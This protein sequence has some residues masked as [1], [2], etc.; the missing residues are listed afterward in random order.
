MGGG[1]SGTST[2]V[3]NSQ[4]WSG[5]EPY[6]KYGFN[7]AKDIY[8]SGLPQYYPGS[9]VVPFSPQTEAALQ[10]TEN[11]ALMGNPLN[12][13]AQNYANSVLQ[14]DYLNQGNPYIGQLTQ[15]ISD[16]ITPQVQSA[17]AGAN[18]SG[19]A[20]QTE[21]L[22]RGMTNALAP[23][24]FGNY[25]QE[26]G[27]QQQAM[28]AAPGLAATDYQDL[29]MLGQVGAQREDLQRQ[30]LGDQ[31]NRWDFSQNMPAQKLAQYMGMLQGGTGFGTQTTQQPLY[32]NG[33]MTGLGALGTI[34]G[35]GG[36]L[37][38]PFGVF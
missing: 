16:Q 37:F 22:S 27:M 6:L 32:E 4:P 31:M 23:Y 9:T 3:Q 35:I 5:V 30:I 21:A 33:L 17:W 7:E 19:G 11:R 34:A 28:G 20:G 36:S 12:F 18:R 24:M 26:R 8:R 13:G 1:E 38:G 25:Q 29:G 10:G 2:T 15:S 14:G